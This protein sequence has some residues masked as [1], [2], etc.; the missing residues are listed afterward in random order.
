[1]IRLQVRWVSEISQSAFRA[2]FRAN[3][4]NASTQTFVADSAAFA[5]LSDVAGR[6]L[7]P[8]QQATLGVVLAEHLAIPAHASCASGPLAMTDTLGAVLGI[9]QFALTAGGDWLVVRIPEWSRPT[10]DL[11]AVSTTGRAWRVELKSTAPLSFT[12][13][14]GDTVDLC[15]R[16]YSRRQDARDQ[17]SAQALPPLHGV[18]SIV[19]RTGSAVDPMFALGGVAVCISTLADAGFRHRKDLRHAA[20]Q[21]CPSGTQGC[22]D[23]CLKGKSVPAIGVLLGEPYVTPKVINAGRGVWGRVLA[24]SISG[25][26]AAWAGASYVGD[27]AIQ[28]MIRVLRSIKRD[29]DA[30]EAN[31]ALEILGGLLRTTRASSS[32]PVRVEAATSFYKFA[33]EWPLDMP[34]IERLMEEATSGVL[35]EQAIPERVSLTNLLRN[36]ATEVERE[37]K[38]GDRF[39][40]AV[41]HG[42]ELRLTP[43]NA[44][45]MMSIRDRMLNPV[46]DQLRDAM[47]AIGEGKTH[48]EDTS[49]SVEA[50]ER[51]VR[52]WVVGRKV[53]GSRR[54]STWI[55]RDGRISIDIG[56]TP[57]NG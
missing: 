26:H 54:S 52:S 24:A 9:A 39:Y 23:V 37:V 55:A 46:E 30:N 56:T 38:L 1:M 21:S 16:M 25:T 10:P 45:D 34:R 43:T 40:A 13:P 44:D 3:V 41:V 11:L 5:I 33:R 53:V 48:F 15:D 49:V 12:H 22:A 18:P 31:A 57:P 50:T 6:Y 2:R 29:L 27:I 19:S 17:L 14:N 47:A 8:T 7:T 4:A 42:E 51:P 20:R 32:I 35:N 36:S 28:N